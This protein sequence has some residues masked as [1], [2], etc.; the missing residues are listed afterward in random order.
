MVFRLCTLV[1]VASWHV[2]AIRFGV[3]KT[4][5][6]STP[7]SSQE[8]GRKEER[9]KK[10]REEA[11]LTKKASKIRKKIINAWMW[12]QPAIREN[13]LRSMARFVPIGKVLEVSGLLWVFRMD[14]IW[15]GVPDPYQLR[16]QDLVKRWSRQTKGAHADL[17]WLGGHSPVVF[18]QFV[19]D[20]VAWMVHQAEYALDPVAMK[21]IAIVLVVKGCTHHRLLRGI[22]EQM[23]AAW[24]HKGIHREAV[25]PLILAAKVRQDCA[26]QAHPR[27]RREVGSLHPRPHVG[28][29]DLVLNLSDEAVE[30]AKVFISDK[31]KEYGVEDLFDQKPRSAIASVAKL[32]RKGLDT[33]LVL[34]RRAEIC[35][36]SSRS[37]SRAQVVSAFRAWRTFAVDHFGYEDQA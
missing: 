30:S 14:E 3:R 34:I 12:S 27:L 21:K 17:A 31:V 9:K 24:F 26:A 32:N 37:S 15:V 25:K 13:A 16:R 1:L 8:R 35:R 10:A 7:S 2:F 6:S 28:G 20:L 18:K 22:G 19:E 23:V 36:L 4:S 33:S 5:I 11:D 29:E